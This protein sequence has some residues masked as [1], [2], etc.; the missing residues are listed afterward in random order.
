MKIIDD[1]V[2]GE[3]HDLNVEAR[4]LQVSMHVI[5]L[6]VHGA[7]DFDRE[8][9]ARRVEIDD[10]ARHRL[11]PTKAHAHLLAANLSPQH[12]LRVSHVAT[13][14]AGFVEESCR[15]SENA[16]DRNNAR[17]MPTNERVRMRRE[18]TRAIKS[19]TGTHQ[20]ND[21]AFARSI[22]G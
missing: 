19:E 6:V 5:E 3:S 10:V 4:E 7:V 22:A 13:Q 8:L 16:H 9:N 20:R 17:A 21:S 14:F 15:S 11:L 18:R 2:V 1:S 12:V